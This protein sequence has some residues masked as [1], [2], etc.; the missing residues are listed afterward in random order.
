[1]PELS[2]PIDA[3]IDKGASALQKRGASYLDNKIDLQTGHVELICRLGELERPKL[4]RKPGKP[5]VRVPTKSER[6]R[7]RID[8]LVVV[9]KTAE[10]CTYT[11][12]D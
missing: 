5:V 1:M 2:A 6:L 9:P 11:G 12:W 3:A 4:H 8:T 10:N 7:V